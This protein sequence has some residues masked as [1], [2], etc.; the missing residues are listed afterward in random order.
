MFDPFPSSWECTDTVICLSVPGREVLMDARCRWTQGVVHSWWDVL[1]KLTWVLFLALTLPACPVRFSLEP[2]TT[3]LLPILSLKFPSMC[4]SCVTPPSPDWS[5]VFDFDS[6]SELH[7]WYPL[8][9][10][11]QFW[12]RTT[13]LPV[14]SLLIRPDAPNKSRLLLKSVFRLLSVMPCNKCAFL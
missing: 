5:M 9:E 10:P 13:P 3:P 2:G 8:P 14:S 4:P 1:S 7:I 11:P 6:A 12:H